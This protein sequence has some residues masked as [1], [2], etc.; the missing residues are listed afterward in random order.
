[1]MMIRLAS[2]RTL[3]ECD[4]AKMRLESCGIKCLIRN[5]FGSTTAGAGIT[6]S[7]SYALPE[8]WVADDEQ[9]EEAKALL[10]DQEKE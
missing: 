9:V 1:L 5:E 7:L 10:S 3:G 4:L 8:L 2:Y 6:G